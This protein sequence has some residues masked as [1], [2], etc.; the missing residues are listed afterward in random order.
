MIGLYILENWP[1]TVIVNGQTVPFQ[2]T[3]SGLPKEALWTW[4]MLVSARYNWVPHQSESNQ[5]LA[6]EILCTGNLSFHRRQLVTQIAPRSIYLWIIWKI[7]CSWNV[8]SGS[9]EC[10]R[11]CRSL[12][13][14]PNWSLVRCCLSQLNLQLM[15]RFLIMFNN[16]WLNITFIFCLRA[17]VCVKLK[18]PIS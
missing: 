10:L 9:E 1:D 5:A 14:I 16:D 4:T 13:N 18:R 8:T 17:V 6:S 2:L 12:E 3:L 7:R 11:C 15:L